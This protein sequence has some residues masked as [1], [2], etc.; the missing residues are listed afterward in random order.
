MT[1]RVSTP[2]STD[3]TLPDLAVLHEAYALPTLR[4]RK[5]TH[6]ELWT[7]LEAIV[8]ESPDIEMAEIGRSA[9]G[10]PLRSLTFGSGPT[11]VLLW[12]QMHGD[13]PTHT[14]GLADLFAYWRREP[15]DPRV[16]KLRDA[17]TVVAVPM[18]NPDG[19]ERFRRLNG[20]GIDLNQ[21]ARA[22]LTPEMRAL[23]DLY[24]RVRP[25]FAFGL[26]DQN[27]RKR[28]GQSDRLVALAL[29]ANP[30]NEE[31]EDNDPRLRAK[32]VC[33]VVREAVEP[34]T[35]ER[36]ARFPDEYEP[37]GMGEYVVSH[38]TSSILMEAGFWPNDPEKQ[39]PRRVSFVALLSALEAIADGS[40]AEM[41][42]DTYE[43]LEET[44]EQ[45]HDLIIRG[46]MVV[47]P[48]VQ[49]YRADIGIDFDAPLDLEGGKVALVGELSEPTARETLD[50][51]DLFVHAEREALHD[52]GRG[53]PTLSD[54]MRACFTVREGV[55]PDSRAVYRVRDGLVLE[56]E[57]S[58]GEE[59]D[60]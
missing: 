60:A 24:N 36:V 35:G 59:G 14:M 39:F 16:A 47:V 32:R 38:G 43:T 9:R 30:F 4:S 17:L 12:S 45:V 50:A 44:D 34:L 7:L 27:V 56:W 33:A 11:R 20:Q 58:E 42:L 8:E 19:A 18:L 25:D 51:A 22:W 5:F 29:L 46:G 52:A 54:G 40:Y 6:A 48:G 28:V 37:K 26:H 53:E 41:P 15:E 49:P 21:D 13:E 31:R 1:D 55:E 23:R 57:N 2:P 3:A 10:R